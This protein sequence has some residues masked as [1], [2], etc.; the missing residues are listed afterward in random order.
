MHWSCFKKYG[1]DCERLF[2]IN[3]FLVLSDVLV[4]LKEN[5]G[6]IG[7]DAVLK[8]ERACR[9]CLVTPSEKAGQRS[10]A[11]RDFAMAA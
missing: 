3:L 8:K 5:M 6:A 10:F 9:G 4:L 2:L 7:F 11:E 1:I